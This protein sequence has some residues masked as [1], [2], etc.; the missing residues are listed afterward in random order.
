M[1]HQPSND[2]E[3]VRYVALFF[4]VLALWIIAK[5]FVLQIIQHDYYSLFALNSHEIYKKIHPERGQIFFTDS[6]NKDEHP[7]AVN[8]TFYLLYA[9]PKEILPGEVKNISD[10]L[11]EVLGFEDDQKNILFEKLAKNNDAYEVVAKKITEEQ[12]NNIKNSGLKGVYFTPQEYRYYP[13]DNLAA[14]VLGFTSLSDDG[15]LTGKYGL[16]G[17]WDKGLAGTGGFLAGERGAKG[18]WIDLASR[19]SLAPENGPDLVLTI[20][21][22]LER[23]ACERLRAGLVE[24]KAKSAALILMNPA[25]GAILAMCSLPDFDPNNYSQSSNMAAFNNTAVF[26]PYEPGSVFKPVTMAAGLDLGLVDPFTTYTDPCDQLIDG[27]RIHNADRKCYGQQTMTQVLEKSINTGVVW[28][29]NKVGTDR[30]REYVE[31]FGFGKKT[32]ISLNTESDGNISSLEKGGE[33]FGATGS[34]GQGLTVTPLQ[35][36]AAYSAIANGGGLPRPYIVSETRYQ[37]GKIE[38]TKPEVEQIIS[39]RAAK[40]LNG[41]LVSVVENHY[42]AA[43]IKTYY[44]AGKTGTAQVPENGKYSDERTNHTF[45]GFAPADNPQFVLVV[46]YEEPARKW[47]EQTALPVFRDVMKFALDYYGVVGKR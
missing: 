3:R 30:F 43:R 22:A 34:Y 46:K 15:N 38:K 23:Q 29:E 31:K 19:I 18:S 14:S 8:K 9:S 4:L 47:A 21:R 10:R 2:H 28:V 27:Y 41:M 35:L 26:T 44:V 6:R 12:M 37:D 5:L 25:T 32:G 42:L 17:Y 20:D 36:A 24:Y 40:L 11:A 45:A 1:Y 13:E 16:E 7:A 33:I 39:A